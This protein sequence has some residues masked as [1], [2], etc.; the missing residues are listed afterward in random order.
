M[1]PQMS[2]ASSALTWVYLVCSMWQSVRQMREDTLCDKDNSDIWTTV[3]AFQGVSE[4]FMH[5]H[6]P[7]H[8][9]GPSPTL[10]QAPSSSSPSLLPSSFFVLR[11]PPPPACVS[12]VLAPLACRGI[13][14]MRS[15]VV[16]LPLPPC[17]LLP[18]IA[19]RSVPH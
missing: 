4:L 2:Q 16:P 12:A 7:S 5:L 17:H 13:R 3:R 11:Q 18:V 19:Q 8:S 9:P 10:S 14:P 15:P 1:V 6:L